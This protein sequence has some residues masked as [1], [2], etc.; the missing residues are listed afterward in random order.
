MM[1]NKEYSLTDMN[2]RFEAVKE[3]GVTAVWV[4]IVN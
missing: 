2:H 3:L 4:D 1:N